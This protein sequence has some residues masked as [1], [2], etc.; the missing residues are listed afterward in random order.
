MIETTIVFLRKED[1]LLLAMKKRGFGEGRFNGT[2]GKIEPGESAAE[3]ARRETLEEIGVTALT[4]T[5]VAELTFHEEH[6]GSPHHVHSHVF[7]CTDWTGEPAETEEMS[8]HW[9]KLSAI[10]YDTMWPDDIH[11]LPNVLLGEKIVGE[12][13][14]DSHDTVIDQTIKTVENFS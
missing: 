13:W 2:G 9:F 11:W 3:C 14:F 12:F 5:K 8:P 1:E 6:D 4:L 7:V 10:P